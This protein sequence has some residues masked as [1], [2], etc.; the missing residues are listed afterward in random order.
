MTRRRLLTASA[1]TVALVVLA[2]ACT[3]D[4]LGPLAPSAD[5]LG[6]ATDLLRILQRQGPVEEALVT[7]IVGPEGGTI[8]LGGDE[9]VVRIPSGALPSATEITLV[10]AAGT[11][12]KYHFSPHGLQ[13]SKPVKVEI[14]LHGTVVEE[15]L[16]TTL[17]LVAVYFDNGDSS[18]PHTVVASELFD[19]TVTLDGRAVFNT[20]HFSGYCLAM[21]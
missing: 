1:L 8:A 10:R 4:A 12:V 15:L 19:V 11:D 6:D 7:Q 21:D 2:S 5:L 13:F 16:G 20:T 9:L 3:T 14:D 17:G 18:E